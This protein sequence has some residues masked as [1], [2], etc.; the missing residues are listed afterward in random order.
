MDKYT[1]HFKLTLSDPKQ[2]SPVTA[3]LSFNK[4]ESMVMYN[5]NEIDT[6]I[7]ELEQLKKK[8]KKVKDQHEKHRQNKTLEDISYLCTKE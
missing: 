3:T 2:P 4:E 5:E 7:E 6:F 8:Y 1:Y